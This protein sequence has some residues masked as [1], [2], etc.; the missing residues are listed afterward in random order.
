[1]NKVVKWL[2][3]AFAV[4]WVVKDPSGAAAAAHK[5]V[6]FGGQAANS[7]ATLISSV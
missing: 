7:L 6:A 4:W 5:A 3:V 2:I 1:M